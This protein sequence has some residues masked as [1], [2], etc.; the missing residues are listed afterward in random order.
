MLLARNRVRYSE[1]VMTNSLILSVM[2]TIFAM[3][4]ELRD[5]RVQFEVIRG[6][7]E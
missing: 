3:G 4:T 5:S 6:L 2:F 7:A 1:R